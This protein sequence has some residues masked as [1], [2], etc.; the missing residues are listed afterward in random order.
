[1]DTRQSCIPT[2]RQSNKDQRRCDQRP[3][4]EPDAVMA[5]TQTPRLQ[6]LHAAIQAR[7]HEALDRG[8]FVTG[9]RRGEG[10]G[11]G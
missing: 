2:S 11:E 6:D 8:E 1:M 5:V 3:E 9:Q 10:G 7:L 4:I